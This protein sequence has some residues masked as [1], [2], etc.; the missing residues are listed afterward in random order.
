MQMHNASCLSVISL[1]CMA[2]L[3][4]RS[5]AAL[6]TAVPATRSRHSAM[7]SLIVCMQNY[8]L[9]STLRNVLRALI[10]FGVFTAVIT[11]IGRCKPVGDDTSVSLFHDSWGCPCCN[12]VRDGHTEPPSEGQC[13]LN[14]VV[15]YVTDDSVR[16]SAVIVREDNVDKLSQ[17]RDPQ[18]S[19]R[20]TNISIINVPC[21]TLPGVRAGK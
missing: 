12:D 9:H 10:A 13:G 17:V 14:A 6:V 11:L 20:R 1:T 18:Q 15:T 19:C 4:S 7:T 21:L 3:H 5:A 8:V 16:G 2:C